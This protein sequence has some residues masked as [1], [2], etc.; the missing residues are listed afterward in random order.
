MET[1]TKRK[2]QVW[3]SSRGVCFGDR[4]TGQDH[5][6]IGYIFVFL[7]GYGLYQFALAAFKLHTL[8]KLIK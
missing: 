2:W 1:G 6:E 8:E 7:V 3:L 5:T 4:A